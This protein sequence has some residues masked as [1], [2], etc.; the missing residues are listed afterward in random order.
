MSAAVEYAD[1]LAAK[2]Q[3]ADEAGFP[4]LDPGDINPALMPHQR[5]AVAWAVRGGRRAIFASF[6]LGKT[7]IQL[8]VVRL[9]MQHVGPRARGLIAPTLFDLDD[10]LAS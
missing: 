5:D 9:T 6:G 3:V 1:F 10:D 8:E 4:D 7:I 2:A